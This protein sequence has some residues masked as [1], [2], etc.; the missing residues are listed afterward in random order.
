MN[1]KNSKQG[2][3]YSLYFI[4]LIILEIF[5]PFQNFNGEL[6]SVFFYVYFF[7]ILLIF[8]NHFKKIYNNFLNFT[9]VTIT[10]FIVFP[11]I[12]TVLLYNTSNNYTFSDEY[13]NHIKKEITIELENYKDTDE[14]KILSKKLPTKLKGTVFNDSLIGKKMNYKDGYLI[15]AQE[16]VNVDPRD[17]ELPNQKYSVIFYNN[18]LQKK[19]SINIQN[20]NVIE[21]INKKINTR[22]NFEKKR[23]NPETELYLSDIWLDSV[24][25][26]VFSNFKPIGRITQSIQLLQVILSF[27][28]AYML[29]TFLDNFKELKVTK[30]E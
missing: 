26:F 2:S 12:H 16:L 13:L 24:T 10:L 6:L 28:F 15:F 30:I 27:I 1:F 11:I 18:K 4:P 23:Q 3:Y 9:L 14:L 25:V 5:K 17:R 19:A 7:I 21:G 8:H 20:E 22:I 29:T